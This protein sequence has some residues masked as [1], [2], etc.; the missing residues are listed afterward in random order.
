LLELSNPGN[1][2]WLENEWKKEFNL[3]PKLTYKCAFTL[4]A[5]NKNKYQ[6][7]SGHLFSDSLDW[8]ISQQNDDYGFGPW[9]RHS[10][11][12]DPWCTGISLIGLLQHP[13]KVPKQVIYNCL[14]WL[15]EKQLPNGLWSYHYIEEGSIWALYALTEG[16]RFL[17]RERK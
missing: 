7:D 8:L 11:G 16:Y 13:D 4:M 9:K 3:D 5:F 10:M 17:Y 6:F 15:K 14:E 12:S 1:L 2:K